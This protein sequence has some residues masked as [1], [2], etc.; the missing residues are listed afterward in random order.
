MSSVSRKKMNSNRHQGGQEGGRGD[1]IAHV[2]LLLPRPAISGKGKQ[3][4]LAIYEIL[5]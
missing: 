2:Y 1:V 3:R 5:N 4:L